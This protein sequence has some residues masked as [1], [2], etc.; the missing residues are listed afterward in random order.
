MAI[1]VLHVS[2]EKKLSEFLF[3]PCL[4]WFS[5]FSTTSP[6]QRQTMC[7]VNHV[8]LLTLTC[9]LIRISDKIL[10]IL[11]LKNSCGIYTA[12]LVSVS[13][14]FITFAQYKEFKLDV[15]VFCFKVWYRVHCKPKTIS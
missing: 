10:S 9:R 2:V 14:S 11:C 6:G 7:L 1:T 13:F 15:F 3:L 12:A 8:S 5:L 4:Q